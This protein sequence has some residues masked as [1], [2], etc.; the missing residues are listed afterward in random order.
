M[1]Y[2]HLLYLLMEQERDIH[3]HTLTQR[4]RE[5]AI[6]H[7]IKLIYGHFASVNTQLIG[8][9]VVEHIDCKSKRCIFMYFIMYYPPRTGFT[10]NV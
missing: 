8:S 9:W 4:E 10:I 6:N 3:T 5:R 1:L 2:V 7:V